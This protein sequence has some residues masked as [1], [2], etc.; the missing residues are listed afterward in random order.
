MKY[1]KILNK[2][3]RNRKKRQMNNK[4][5]LKKSKKNKSVNLAKKNINLGI[6]LLRMILSFLIVLVHDYIRRVNTKIAMF[7]NRFLPYYVPCF[8]LIGFYFS[9]NTIVSRNIDKIKQRFIRI[10]IPYMGWPIIFWLENNYY[11]Y[12]Y[13]IYSRT[14]FKFLYTQLLIGCGLHG[15]LWFLF[16]LLFISILFTIFVFMFKKCFLIFLFLLTIICYRFEFSIYQ[17]IFFNK[18][19]KMPIKHSIGPIPRSIIFSFTGFFLGSINVINK[20]YKFRIITILFFGSLLFIILYYDLLYRVTFFYQGFIIDLVA[21]S[22]FSVFSMIPFDKINNKYIFS[23]L[24][25]ITSHT[26]GVYYLHPK[27]ADMFSKY[28]EPIRLRF[29]KGCVQIYLISYLICFIGTILFRRTYIKFL[30][31]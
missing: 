4:I 7:P 10:I 21:I 28:F 16:N 22:A 6:E 19:N 8:F 30:F 17:N 27:V 29:F 23:I 5:I 20:Y 3:K 18:F 15:I 9:F 13:R 14:Q 25:I 2:E 26:G 1:K 12:R 24:K 31:N 11:Y